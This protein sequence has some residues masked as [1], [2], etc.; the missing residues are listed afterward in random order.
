MADVSPMR[1]RA[2][3]LSLLLLAASTSALAFLGFGGTSWKE[4]VLLHDGSKIVVTRTVERGGR[5]EI[6]QEPPIKQQSLSFILPGTNEEL[7]WVDK[8]TEDIGGANFLPMQLEIHKDISYLVAYPMGCASYNKWGRPNPPY[9]IFR[10]QGKAWQRITLQELP[11][12]LTVP[13]LIFSSPDREANKAG[14]RIVSAET[15]RALYQ[16]YRQPEHKTIVREAVKGGLGATSCPISSTVA[17]KLIAPE[18]D[19]KLL[20]YNWWPLAQDWLNNTYRA[21]R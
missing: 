3:L 8:F 15:I 1:T 11:E 4:E 9:V 17:G 2:I 19:G 7:T 18:I 12:E 14:Q 10:H 16:G 6:G 20:Y 21:S 13:N 5:H